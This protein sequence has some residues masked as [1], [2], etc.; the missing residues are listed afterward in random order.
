MGSGH[1]VK[2]IIKLN[3][4]LVQYIMCTL[5]KSTGIIFNRKPSERHELFLEEPI[6][7][8]VKPL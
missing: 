8:V 3:F 6:F 2:C 5:Q 4:H 1:P 7:S